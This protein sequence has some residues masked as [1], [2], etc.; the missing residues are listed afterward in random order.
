MTQEQM[1]EL[2][3]SATEE[4]RSKIGFIQVVI[5]TFCYLA[6]IAINDGNAAEFLKDFVDTL[7]LR[8]KVKESAG[9]NVA[10]DF[11]ARS[12]CFIHDR[13]EHGKKAVNKRWNKKQ[14]PTE[15]FTNENP[16]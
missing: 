14:Q 6:L 4:E 7:M 10:Y 5:S 13:S 3:K 8:K 12:Y 11:L 16:F 1:N 15:Q 9:A 2:Y